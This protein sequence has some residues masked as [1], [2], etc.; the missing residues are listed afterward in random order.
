LHKITHQ[1]NELSVTVSNE[2]LTEWCKAAA[3]GGGG[4]GGGGGRGAA[5]HLRLCRRA[6]TLLMLF[7]S[8]SLM[9]L[10][11]PQEDKT[12]SKPCCRRRRRWR[13]HV[14]QTRHPQFG[15][16]GNNNTPVEWDDFEL[17][18]RLHPSPWA[19]WPPQTR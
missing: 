6:C 19:W 7:L 5:V 11:S 18:E 4:G 12:V 14:M 17:E 13:L 8:P 9:L 10:L 16:D 3:T 1:H 15:L 2:S